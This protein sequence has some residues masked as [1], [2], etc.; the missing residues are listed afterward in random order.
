MRKGLKVVLIVVIAFVVVLG[1]SIAV[2]VRYA[3]QII[4]SELESRLG[5]SFSIEKIDLKWGHVEV[6]G[7]GFKKPAGKEV[8]KVGD[9]SV[10]ADFMGLLRRQYIVSIVI[11]KDPYIFVE[12]DNKGNIVNPVLPPGL[13]YRPAHRGKGAGTAHR[14]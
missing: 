11:V 13:G 10:T 5:K 3:N 14:E 4:K 8:I 1:G 6:M 9:I 2:L 12:I 7:I